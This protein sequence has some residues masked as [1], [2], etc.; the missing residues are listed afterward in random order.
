MCIRDSQGVVARR[1]VTLRKLADANQRL[2]RKIEDDIEALLARNVRAGEVNRA[3]GAARLDASAV[4][5]AFVEIDLVAEVDRL[6]RAGLHAGVAAGAN[7]E[8]DRVLLP[9]FDLEGAE[10]AA[11]ARDLSRPHRV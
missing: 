4:R 3:D 9:P 11:E 7:L 1:E 2:A 6:F 8:V 10:P 5:L